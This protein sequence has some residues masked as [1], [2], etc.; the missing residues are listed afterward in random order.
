MNPI[1]LKLIPP[2][3]NET[4]H[5]IKHNSTASQEQQNGASQINSAIQNVYKT[6]QQNA[7]TAASMTDSSDELIKQTIYKRKQNILDDKKL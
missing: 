5:H 3:I 7:K 4:T 6:T 2:L 1:L